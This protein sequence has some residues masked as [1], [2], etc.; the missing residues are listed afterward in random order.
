[1]SAIVEH[2]E[3][4]ENE[5]VESYQ[6]KIAFA[7]TEQTAPFALRCGAMM[8]DYI[9]PAAII[10]IGTLFTRGLYGSTRVSL[11]SY[12]KIGYITASLVA[13]L[14][15]F[16]LA[17]LS[18]RTIGKWFAGLRIVRKDGKPAAITFILLRHLVGYPLST[19]LFFSG[20]LLA[21]VTSNGRALHDYL[22]GT[23]VVQYKKADK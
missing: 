7:L 12:D 21:A 16:L 8:I 10:V 19:L 15:L 9:I 2:R 14:N 1:M 22:A 4:V 5:A 13:A 18:G 17:P 11:S 20:F 6:S 23:I 3:I